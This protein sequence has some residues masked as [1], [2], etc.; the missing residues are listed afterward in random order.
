MACSQNKK[1]ECSNKGKVAK[2]DAEKGI[3]I[4]S[5]TDNK[6][7]KPKVDVFVEASEKGG[8]GS[9]SIS[10]KTKR[11]KTI[12]LTGSGYAGKGY[13]GGDVGINVK[14]PFGRK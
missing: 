14:I 7:N 5:S 3:C 6:K 8:F 10:K 13:K 2:F 12:S 11:G 9:A 4:C 1:R